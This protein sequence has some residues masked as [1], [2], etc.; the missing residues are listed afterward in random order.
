MKAIIRNIAI[1]TFILFVLPYIVPGVFITG[2]IWTLL[3]GAI[4]LTVLFFILK[5]ILSIISLPVNMITLG[6][7]N[8]F[9]NAL[10]VYLLTI[11]VPQIS[12][13]AFTSQQ[14]D[15]FGIIIPAIQFNTFFAYVATAFMVSIIEWFIKWLIE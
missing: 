6:I 4:V 13:V 1:Y 8:L 10:L 11:L 9:I 2:G 3:V 5:P 7:F 14:L 12:V 15:I